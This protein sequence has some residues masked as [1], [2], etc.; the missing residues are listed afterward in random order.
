MVIVFF[1]SSLVNFGLHDYNEGVT[2]VILRAD[3]YTCDPVITIQW[4]DGGSRTHIIIILAET[5][6]LAVGTYS[7]SV[8]TL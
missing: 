7:F 6:K 8:F 4:G 3:E 1:L 5:E 2:A